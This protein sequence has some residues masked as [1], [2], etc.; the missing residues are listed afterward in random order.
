MIH[1]QV[2][3]SEMTRYFSPTNTRLS[4]CR[5][6]EYLDT[7]IILC[8]GKCRIWPIVGD[9][10]GA[11]HRHHEAQ[12][13]V[14]PERAVEAEEPQQT[15]VHLQYRGTGRYTCSTEV[16]VDTTPAVQI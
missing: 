7:Q 16:Q 1:I 13:A 6:L 15:G 2:E 4:V 3:S 8:Y 9:D 11:V 12:P 5:Y 14:Q 10:P